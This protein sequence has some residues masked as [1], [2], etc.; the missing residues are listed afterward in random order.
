MEKSCRQNRH[1]K[2]RGPCGT[3]LYKGDWDSKPLPSPNWETEVCYF[4]TNLSNVALSEL[5]PKEIR[6]VEK[7]SRKLGWSDMLEIMKKY[8][9]FYADIDFPKTSPHLGLP[10]ADAENELPCSPIEYQPSQEFLW[11]QVSN[12]RVDI[13]AELTQ[14]VDLDFFQRKTPK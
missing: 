5:D 1:K 13:M 12:E 14:E 6:W 9:N 7:K 11:S 2:F 8:P 3:L 10:L 4:D